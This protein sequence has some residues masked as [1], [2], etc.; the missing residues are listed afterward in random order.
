MKSLGGDGG[1]LVFRV[2]AKRGDYYYF[3]IGQ[4]G[5]YSLYRFSSKENRQELQSGSSSSIKTGLNQ[6]NLLSVVARGAQIAVFVNKHPIP[7]ITHTAY[8]MA[9][10]ALPP[11]DAN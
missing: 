5:T 4:T 10:I 6:V 2:R 7:K 11:D 1:G 9:Q 3:G 8:Q